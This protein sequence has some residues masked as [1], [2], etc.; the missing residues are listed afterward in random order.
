[1]V[2]KGDHNESLVI[3]HNV[4]NSTYTSPSDIAMT[5]ISL[6]NVSMAVIAVSPRPVAADSAST[7]AIVAPRRSS[8][9]H[10]SS[11]ASSSYRLGRSRASRIRDPSRP[12][13][14]RQDSP[15]IALHFGHGVEQAFRYNEKVYGLQFHV[16][17]N[18]ELA[19]VIAE[20]LPDGALE[21]GAVIRASRWGGAMLDRFLA[22]R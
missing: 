4:G 3:R 1:M 10:T 22:L 14:V 19:G 21:P 17:I 20:Q 16:E 11:C 13:G 5:A 12:E 2:A 8:S 6:S 18:S 9:A 7:H 15:G